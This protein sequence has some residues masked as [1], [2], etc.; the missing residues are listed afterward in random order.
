[1]N[2]ENERKRPK[3]RYKKFEVDQFVEKENSFLSICVCVS[4]YTAIK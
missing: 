3:K 2:I 1:M 4:D